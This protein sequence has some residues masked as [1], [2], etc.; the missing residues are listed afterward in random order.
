MSL[1]AAEADRQAESEIL[2]DQT[3]GIRGWFYRSYI[4]AIQ[5]SLQGIAGRVLDVGCGEDLILARTAVRRVSVDISMIRLRRFEGG[6][7]VCGDARRLP[8]RNGCFSAV[9]LS[10]ILEHLDDPGEA[11][12]E[13]RRCLGAGGRAVV[14]LPNDVWMS[15]GR[16]LIGLW[17]PRHP[18]HLVFST[19]G[20][21]R[22]WAADYREAKAHGLPWP[23]LP[24]ALNMYWFAVLEALSDKS[25]R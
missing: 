23:K 17:P 10:A 2:A 22:Q 13:S 1:D 8:F 9:V 24:F 4:R 3:R 11:L 18:D 16:V 15:I 20:R 6:L 12:R 7:R 21:L 19:P 5:S 14:V 25:R